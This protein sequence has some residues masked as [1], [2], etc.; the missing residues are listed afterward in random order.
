MTQALADIERLVAEVAKDAVSGN[1][2]LQEKMEALKLLQPYYAV[3]KKVKSKSD[4]DASGGPSMG[5]MQHSLRVVEQEPAETG[6]SANGGIE[7]SS[8]RAR[9]R[10]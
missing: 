4:D 6:G 7:T 2:T 9:N 5:D 1:K 3:L 10:S 8:R